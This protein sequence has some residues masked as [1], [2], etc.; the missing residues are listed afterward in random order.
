MKITKQVIL[1]T[2]AGESMLVPVGDTVAQYNGLFII[3]PSAKLLWEA[4]QQGKEGMD[5]AD[6]LVDAYGIDRATA[7]EDA[8]AFVAKLRELGIVE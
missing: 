1:R 6:V 2:I 4:I 8:N 7:Q 5:L 3:T